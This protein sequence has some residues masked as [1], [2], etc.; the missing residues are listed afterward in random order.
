MICS[1]ILRMSSWAVF[2]CSLRSMM[3]SFAMTSRKV[4]SAMS[5]PAIVG[6]QTLQG[7]HGDC[8]ADRIATGNPLGRAQVVHLFVVDPYDRCERIETRT[9]QLVAVAPILARL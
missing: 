1:P 6:R 4:G 7:A 2:C 3:A 5:H 9:C 8:Y